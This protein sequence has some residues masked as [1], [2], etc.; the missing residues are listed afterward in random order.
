[1]V[2]K[3]DSLKRVHHFAYDAA[4]TKNSNKKECEFSFFVA[5]CLLIKQRLEESGGCEVNLPD[6][7]ITLSSKDVF[8]IERSVTYSYTTSS[9]VNLEDLRIEEKWGDLDVDVVGCL[10]GFVLV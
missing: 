3:G 1:M 4:A 2:R 10:S 9:Q 7:K 6:G 5:A 8:G